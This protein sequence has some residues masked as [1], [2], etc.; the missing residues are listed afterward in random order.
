[1]VVADSSVALVVVQVEGHLEMALGLELRLKLV[2]LE[3]QAELATTMAVQVFMLVAE[4]VL[5]QL[6]ALQQAAQQQVVWEALV[7]A[8]L[9]LLIFKSLMQWVQQLV[10]DNSYLEIT[11][12]QVVVAE[13]RVKSMLVETGFAHLDLAA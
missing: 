6:E 4:A 1:V 11:S 5:E 9:V 12:T 3:T 8:A 7:L 13:V 10:L 2:A